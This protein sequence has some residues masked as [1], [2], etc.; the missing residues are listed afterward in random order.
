M[1]VAI[2]AD[3]AGFELKTELAKFIRGLGYDVTDLGAHQ[4]DAADDYPD[5][6]APVAREVQARKADKGIVICGSGVG[7]SIVANKFK[8]VRAAMCHDT[9]SAAQGVEHDDMNVLCMGSRV[10]GVALA[11]EIVR[12]FLKANM[13][14]HPRFRRR[15][16]KL[17]A[18]EAREAG[19]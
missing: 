14:P 15:L 7:A 9:Y 11:Q 5:L 2:G 13:D 17:L 19:L 12:A 1:K 4:F 16:E 18:I 10:I 8:G 6:A 3:H